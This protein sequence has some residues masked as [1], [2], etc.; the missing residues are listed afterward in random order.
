MYIKH[1]LAYAAIYIIPIL[2][3]VAAAVIFAGFFAYNILAGMQQTGQTSQAVNISL[4]DITANFALFGGGFFLAILVFSLVYV[5]ASGAIIRGAY[6]SETQQ[7]FPFAQAWKESFQRLGK[8]VGLSFRFFFYT[9]GWLLFVIFFVFIVQFF[10]GFMASKGNND[11][12]A[13][14]QPLSGFF[15]LMPLVLIAAMVFFI[16]RMC[17][18]F[19]AFPIL[20]STDVSSKEA[21]AQSIKISKGL[22]GRIFGNLFLL[23]LLAALLGGIVAQLIIQ[24]YG[25][26]VPAPQGSL[27]QTIQYINGISPYA[28][29]IPQIFV[30]SFSGLFNYVFMKKAIEANGG[31]MNTEMPKAPSKQQGPIIS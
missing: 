10:A 5:I 22:A 9:G 25:T 28:G 11:V 30:A 26:F 3:N 31:Q 2:V 12:S 24:L 20:L 1:F 4:P 6:L 15:T 16:A 7:K 19:F 23:S 13:M 8:M 14:I 21:L 17:R 18:A 29:I 27:L